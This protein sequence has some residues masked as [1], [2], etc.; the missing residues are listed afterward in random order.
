[1]RYAGGCHCGAIRFSFESERPLA[2]RACLCSFCRKHGARTVSDPQGSAWIEWDLEPLRYRFA[3]RAADY[4]ICLRCGIYIGAV[5]DEPIATL[6]LNTFQEPRLDLA[7][8][9]VSYEDEW[10]DQ[11]AERRRSRWTP[12]RPPSA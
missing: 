11:K 2:P 5:T 9:P 6:N 12:L 3:S 7:P 10:P 4:I 8:S 1:M